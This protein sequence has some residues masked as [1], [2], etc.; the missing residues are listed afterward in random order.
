MNEAFATEYRARFRRFYRIDAAGVSSHEK[1]A[2]ASVAGGK[3]TSRSLDRLV[4]PAIRGAHRP[5][6]NQPLLGLVV[7]GALPLGRPSRARGPTFAR[8]PFARSPQG[9]ASAGWVAP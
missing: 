2:L 5:D 9:C 7:E 1:G 8:S 4:R 3:V 6:E